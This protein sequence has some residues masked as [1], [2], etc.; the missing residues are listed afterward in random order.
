MS[1]N[2][3]ARP[4][5]DPTIVRRAVFESFKKLDP[6]H[7]VR[8]PVMFTVFVGSILTT[9]LWLQAAF[10]T[11]GE[12]SAGFIFGITAW[13]WFTVLFA[14]FAE[15]MAEGRGKAQA[16][17]L[18]ASRREVMAK[19][20]SD[21][22]RDS[23]FTSVNAIAL[24]KGD[25]VLVEA[26][27]Q[28]P[29]DGEV[30]EGVASVDE[31]AITGESAPV[32]RESGGD[33]SSVTGGTRVLSD[34]LIVRV[35]VNP[36]ETIV[37][38]MIS[39]VEGAKRQKTPNEI[40]LDI[41]L[42]AMT[43]IFLLACVT[44]LPFSIYGVNETIRLTPEAA[45]TAHPITVTV[46][47]ALLVC[48]IPTT[49]GGLLSAIGIAG[50]DRMIQ[51][52]VI[53]MSGRAVEAA[54]D[55]DVLLLDKTGTITLGNRQAVEFST[56]NGSSIE[57]LA[58]AAQLSSLADET[59]EGR[60]IVVLAKE[61]YGLRGRAL[62]EMHADFIPFSAQTRVSGV[63]L[64]GRQIRKGAADAIEQFVTERG[65]E[66]PP[67]LRRQVEEISKRGGTPLVVAENKKPL[68]VIYLKDIVKGG[69][70][71]RF[72]E[73]RQMGIKTVMITG[74]NP[75]TAAAIAAE[76]G[77]D[78]FLAQATPEAKLKMIRD[79]QAGGR[80]VAMTGDGTNDSPALA[81]ADV[82]V[83]MNTGTQAAKEAGNM[84]DLD[85]NPTKLIEIVEIGKQLLMTRGALTTFSIANDVAKYSRSSRRRSPVRTRS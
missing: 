29:V 83:A 36:G 33:R 48:L 40:A 16:D 35:A 64:N 17:S 26:G 32:I 72:A 84:V 52:N 80:L 2:T 74:D 4:L 69:I 14:N 27:E 45:A 42:A 7:Q 49:I 39:L 22:S 43:I 15:A 28:I 62:N 66:Y 75:L 6:R 73:L 50:M 79:Y 53:A 82:A 55:V 9:G 37:D 77:V 54:G 44:L 47:V 76:A 56:V 3:K 51:A 20:L 23:H 38:R 58:D 68:G 30:I 19:K 65:G 41:L 5:F 57:T 31:S 25:I 21:P 10:T 8:N 85:S 11:H 24:R 61:K 67:E 63:N 46:L 78:D 1:A 70:K 71:E 81:Q 34:W 59:P 12:A 60:S 13:L 18:R